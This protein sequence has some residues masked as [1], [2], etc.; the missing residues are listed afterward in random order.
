MPIAEY[1]LR[2]HDQSALCA[3]DADAWAQLL[4]DLFNAYEL[5]N[6][7]I[8]REIDESTRHAWQTAGLLGA[9]A[10]VIHQ[11]GRYWLNT[12]FHQE[13]EL[14]ERLRA[15][16]L[17]APYAHAPASPP[18][19]LN[20][21]QQ[22][23]W[24]HALSHRLTLIN[25]GPG[26]GKTYT[27]ANIVKSLQ[28]RHPKPRI[29]LTAP[30]GKAAKRMSE[31]PLLQGLN[32]EAAQT[33][34][35][36]LGIGMHGKALYHATQL[37]PYDVVV[38]DEASMLSLQLAHALL[39][40]LS[41]ES[42]LILLGDANQLAAVEAGAV[43]YD[44]SLSEDLAPHR[45]TLQASQRFDE[46]SIIGQLA[47]AVADG[48]QFVQTLHAGW[49]QQALV[50]Q[51]S[52]P[53]FAELTAPYQPYFDGLREGL[54]F[55]ELMKR[56]DS[57]RILSTTHH[58]SYGVQNLNQQLAQQH[59]A[60]CQLPAKMEPFHGQPILMTANDYRLGVFNGDIG[61]CLMNNG[62]LMLYL[63]EREPIPMMHLNPAQYQS[64]YAMTVHK[65]QGSEYGHVALI[66]NED[67]YLSRELLYT[68]I[69][70]AKEQLSLYAS[71]SALRYACAHPTERQ[72]GVL[73][74]H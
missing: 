25:G 66:L 29:A 18:P 24:Q 62:Q 4:R 41:P 57:Y 3:Q 53:S 42:A 10:P 19:S 21:L 43:L 9:N 50:Y 12:L 34:H 45:I 44:L 55:D 60:L 26:T 63:E 33:L 61:L 7:L 46:T 67:E 52:A 40:A 72:T 27:L 65:S 47:R 35:R 14:S 11:N 31:S 22:Q 6:T 23:A 69:S 32:L 73:R 71:E 64:A 74:W 48:A 2:R 56:F 38:V 16:A 30:T 13:R 17:C 68:G 28:E 54:P 8:Y 39:Q 70:R 49:R 15:K 37:L 36:L 20:A 1:Y 58:G 59:K 51:P 5:G